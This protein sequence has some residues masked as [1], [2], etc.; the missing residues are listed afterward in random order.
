MNTPKVPTWLK[1]LLSGF[2]VF[3]ILA[4]SIFGSD[5]PTAPQEKA[6]AAT[7]AP[8]TVS[9]EGFTLLEAWQ[10]AEPGLQKWASDAQP[11]GRFICQGTAP[12]REGR[13]VEW[14]GMAGSLSKSEL[15]RVH[16]LRSEVEV[17][18][19]GARTT[20]LEVFPLEGFR[21]SPEVAATTWD[22]LKGQSLVKENTRLERLGVDAT[23]AAV[24]ECGGGAPAFYLVVID[25]PDGLVCVNPYTGQVS[26]TKFR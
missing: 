25:N 11:S 24:K 21:D 2:G 15:A 6:A 8:P 5:D 9:P 17:L 20:T 10:R 18:P 13:C 26:H 3:L 22:W 4:C 19:S 12:S 16:V 23:A 14:N 7:T 1:T